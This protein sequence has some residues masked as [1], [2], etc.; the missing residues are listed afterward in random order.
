VTLD[1]EVDP[2][3]K[4]PHGRKTEMVLAVHGQIG[5]LRPYR[6]VSLFCRAHANTIEW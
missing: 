4:L 1:I 2:C 3:A 5:R 6:R